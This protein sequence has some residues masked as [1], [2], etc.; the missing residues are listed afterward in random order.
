[1][2]NSM[3]SIN[4]ALKDSGYFVEFEPRCNKYYQA[5]YYLYDKKGNTFT[6]S[7]RLKE[8]HAVAES[9]LRTR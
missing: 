2:K 4:V 6:Y 9:I 5:T 8:I 3:K 7:S 1:M